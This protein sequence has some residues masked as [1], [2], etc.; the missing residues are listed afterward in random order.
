MLL[1]SLSCL[2]KPRAAEDG[3]DRDFP[4]LLSNRIKAGIALSGSQGVREFRQGTSH[5][6]F[7]SKAEG[8]KL[9]L[10]Q[11]FQVIG[12]PSILRGISLLLSSLI[13]NGCTSALGIQLQEFQCVFWLRC[14]N[15]SG[16]FYLFQSNSKLKLVRS[17][18]VCEES[19]GPFVDGLLESQVSPE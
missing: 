6:K 11:G 2:W 7:G 19:S 9:L 5:L 12:Y 3:Q 15:H 17:L 14:C 18:A 16:F 4:V 10:V 13:G 8:I 1:L